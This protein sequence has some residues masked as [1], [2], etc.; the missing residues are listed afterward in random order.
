MSS[1]N[2]MR[3]KRI[4]IG[5][6]LIP[7]FCETL[8]FWKT[9]LDRR[10]SDRFSLS[11]SVNSTFLCNG[12]MDCHDRS[13]EIDCKLV[14]ID[15][16]YLSSVP[17]SPVERCNNLNIIHNVVRLQKKFELTMILPALSGCF[18]ISKKIL[19]VSWIWSKFWSWPCI[20]VLIQVRLSIYRQ[21][22]KISWQSQ[23]TV[24]STQLQSLGK[25]FKTARPV[26]IWLLDQLW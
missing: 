20:N 8:E 6:T 5:Y 26:S 9:E 18:Q 14:K 3:R 4:W 17:P 19:V 25:V 21:G 1:T 24:G 23:L 11:F 10:S 2:K 16:S 22:L 7:H 15:D 13:D 12:N